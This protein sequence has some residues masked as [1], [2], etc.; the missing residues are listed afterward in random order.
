[1]SCCPRFYTSFSSRAPP[2]AHPEQPPN[3]FLYPSP[4]LQSLLSQALWNLC[5][6]GNMSPISWISSDCPF[7]TLSYWP[8]FQGRR[9][10]A[11]LHLSREGCSYTAAWRQYFWEVLASYCHFQNPYSSTLL[12]WGTSHL[13]KTKGMELSQGF[14]I[15]TSHVI[16]F[17]ASWV[18]KF[19]SSVIWRDWVE[20]SKKLSRSTTV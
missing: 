10:G 11:S 1:M 19:K 15:L 16:K 20:I 18:T 5:S 3:Y 14:N 6:R 13:L 7:D 17:K 8:G 9:E 4:L 12:T 2:G